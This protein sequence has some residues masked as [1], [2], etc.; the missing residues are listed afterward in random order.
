MFDRI[1]LDRKNVPTMRLAVQEGSGRRSE[2]RTV[3]HSSK[4]KFEVNRTLPRS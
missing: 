3:V 4:S 2:P 1:P